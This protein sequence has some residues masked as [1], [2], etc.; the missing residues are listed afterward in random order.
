MN[1]YTNIGTST[2]KQHPSNLTKF[3]WLICDNIIISFTNSSLY[4]SSITL[5]FFIATYVPSFKS[6]L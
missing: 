3:L 6:P 4:S 2:S 1:S 5:D